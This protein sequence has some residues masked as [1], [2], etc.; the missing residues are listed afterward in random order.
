MN[1][2]AVQHQ[3][4]LLE[5]LAN[6]EEAMAHLDP[7]MEDDDKAL[8]RL[9]LSRI[10]EAQE[11]GQDDGD[12]RTSPEGWA[13]FQALMAQAD[14]SVKAGRTLSSDE[15]WM[16]ARTRYKDMILTP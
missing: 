13:R 16:Q 1:D 6:P 2:A 7:D 15:F 5:N 3:V 14:E 4:G 9:A 10:F 8:I 11:I 12:L